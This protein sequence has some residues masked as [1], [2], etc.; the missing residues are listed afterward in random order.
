MA[1]LETRVNALMKNARPGLRV[2]LAELAPM[3]G[4]SIAAGFQRIGFVALATGAGKR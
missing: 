4:S 3:R 1:R 2:H